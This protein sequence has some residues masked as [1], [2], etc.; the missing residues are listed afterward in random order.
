VAAAHFPNL[1]P[2]PHLLLRA[3]NPKKYFG[4]E[5][6]YE[7]S[8]E[9]T[10]RRSITATGNNYHYKLVPHTTGKKVWAV[11]S[12]GP[13]PS[14]FSP[15]LLLRYDRSGRQA[16]LLAEQIIPRREPDCVNRTTPCPVSLTV[17]LCF[18]H[19]LFTFEKV[20]V[21]QNNIEE[22]LP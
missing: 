12:T 4:I 14:A 20:R 19:K 18:A 8:R 9:Q 11:G 10:P 5:N 7:A 6:E 1:A 22:V 13:N 3:N 15:N 16:G 17:L 2:K 21:L